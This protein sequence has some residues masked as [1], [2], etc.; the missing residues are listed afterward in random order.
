MSEK[1]TIIGIEET[2]TSTEEATDNYEVGYGKPPKHTQFLKGSSGNPKG[3]PKKALDFAEQLLRAARVPVTI[4]ENGRRV[5]RRR[6][7]VAILQLLNKT[8]AGDMK[9][10]NKFFDLF[11]RA[12]DKEA[13]A[14]AQQSKDAWK[15]ADADS[16]TDGQLE[17]IIRGGSLEEWHKKMKK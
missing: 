8:M 9:A 17:W 12:L 7:D 1:K 16:L 3:R 13:L 5:R 11:P 14:A 4:T 6:C 2:I 10:M 15:Y